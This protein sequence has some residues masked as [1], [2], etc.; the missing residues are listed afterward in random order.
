PHIAALTRAHVD[1]RSSDLS[2]QHPPFAVLSE[3]ER[4]RFFCHAQLS[5]HARLILHTRSLAITEQDVAHLHDKD[6][7]CALHRHRHLFAR[8]VRA[9]ERDVDLLLFGALD[10]IH[11][12]HRTHR[13]RVVA[14]TAVQRTAGTDDWGIQLPQR[15]T[16]KLDTD[17]RHRVV[18]CTEIHDTGFLYA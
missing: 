10:Q 8:L 6:P 18:A 2:R 13:Q 15:I 1:V 11:R 12:V 5:Y 14:F 17:D 3:S 4:W 7:I 16:E 9:F